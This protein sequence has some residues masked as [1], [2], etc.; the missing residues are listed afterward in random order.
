MKRMLLMLSLASAN[1]F[2]SFAQWQ[3]G[4]DIYNTNSGNVGIGIS[5]PQ[6]K[7]DIWAPTGSS[8]VLRGNVGGSVTVPAFEL[9]GYNTNAYNA[10]LTISTNEG[11]SFSE[12]M[13]IQYNG[14]VGIGTT[15]PTSKLAIQGAASEIHIKND[16]TNTLAVGNY[17]G[18]SH[19]IKSINLGIALTPLTFQASKFNFD[20]GNVG[21]GTTSPFTIG[22]TAKLSV[23]ASSGALLKNLT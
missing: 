8:A 18:N 3:N 1:Y 20:T 7:L 9:S 2:S 5:S 14:Y 15:D 16:A 11:G 17:D 19:W 23:N 12:R 13:R 6:A 22:G 21:I 4:T 10:G